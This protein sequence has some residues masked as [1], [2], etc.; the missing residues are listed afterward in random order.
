MKKLI[1]ILCISFIL[2]WLDIFNRDTIS[3]WFRKLTTKN[4]D[5]IYQDTKTK[6]IV[7]K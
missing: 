2:I 3:L 7:I 4:G 1:I 6:N 5:I